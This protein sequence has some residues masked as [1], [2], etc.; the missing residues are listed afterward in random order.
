M[1]PAS[2]DA[3]LTTTQVI[4]ACLVVSAVAAFLLGILTKRKP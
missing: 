2:G 3:M 1:S 4:V